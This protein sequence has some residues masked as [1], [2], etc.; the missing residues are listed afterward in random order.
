ME[1]QIRFNYNVSQIKKIEKDFINNEVNWITVIKSNKNISPIDFLNS[2]IYKSA[3]FDY[4]I[5]TLI[6]LKYVSPN[7]SIRDA[8]TNLQL[9]IKKYNLEFFKSNENYKLFLIL[10]KIKIEKDDPNNLKKLIKKILKEFEEH[11][12]NLKKIEK[13][14]FIKINKKLIKYENQFS[15]YII[16]DIKNIIF[17]KKDLD[18]I[19]KNIIES[20]KKKVGSKYIFN[21]TYPDE[22]AILKDCNVE[23]SRKRMYLTFNSVAQ[24]NLKILNE[25]IKLRD[26]RSKIFGFKNS[27]DY[28]FS[29]N[30]LAKEGKIYNLLKKLIPIL[31]KKSLIEYKEICSIANKD[32]INDY[33]IKYY[34][35]IYKKDILKYDENKIKEYFPSNY[36]INKIMELYGEIFGIS[37]Y[38]IKGNSNQYWASNIDLYKVLD[39]ETSKIMGYLYLDLYPRDGKYTHAA[40]FDLQNTYSNENDSRVI[41]V[42]AIVCN[43]EKSDDVSLFTFDE[44]VTF[45]HE[46]GHGLHFLLSNVKYELLSGISME[47][48][49]GEM[50]SQFFENWCYQPE[51]LKK[52]SL[53]YKDKIK[54]SDELINKI[55]VNKNYLNG[56]HYLTQILY[57]KYDLMIHKE[58]KINKKYLYNLWFKLFKELLPLKISSNIYPMCRFDH[59]IDYSAGYYGYLWSIIYS[60]DAFSLFESEGIFN[61]KLGRRF[62]NNILEV[63]GT[64]D[65]DMMLENFLERNHDLQH[66]FTPLHI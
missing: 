17:N 18:G 47:E 31:K 60:Y 53:H 22:N 45:C 19:D 20:H 61:K 42:C 54:I 8:C 11:G 10:K 41:P 16:N 26:E 34:S 30:R 37:I 56:I 3:K 29:E 6:F 24:K 36:T 48:D 50:P 40:T 1:L 25:I 39:V 52:I 12:A 51:F 33:D 4:I 57:I 55:V 44:I 5:N 35:N 66:F 27:V 58:K 28:Y 14:K 43:F 13:D 7:K 46:F 2:Y 23:E 63:G 64:V 49:F 21:T 59:I 32:N 62:R 38:P 9:E 65:G 15:E